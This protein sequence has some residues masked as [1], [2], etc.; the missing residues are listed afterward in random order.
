LKFHLLHSHSSPL[1]CNYWLLEET[2]FLVF[3]PP[4]IS[5]VSRLWFTHPMPY[6]WLEILI[7][8][9]LSDGVFRMFWLE[10]V[11]ASFG[12]FCCHWTGSVYLSSQTIDHSAQTLVWSLTP[13]REKFSC[14]SHH[15]W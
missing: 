6:F 3:F 1:L 9:V 12:I 2:C 7:S 4:H 13:L 15:S 11:V 10:W 14:R 8:R 5:C